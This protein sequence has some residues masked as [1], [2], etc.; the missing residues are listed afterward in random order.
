MLNRIKAAFEAFKKGHVPQR[1]DVDPSKI[2]A[3]QFQELVRRGVIVLPKEQVLGDGHA[4]FL[5]EGSQEEFEVQEKKDKKQYGI[6]G[7]GL[8]KDNP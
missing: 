6:F 4:E 7:I 5:G 1:F 2:T 3:D 8:D